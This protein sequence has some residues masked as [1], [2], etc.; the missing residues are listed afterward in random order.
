MT[1]PPASDARIV[2][3]DARLDAALRAVLDHPE[4][5]LA[6]LAVVT[7]RDGRVTYTGTFGR[8]FIDDT[9]PAGD[10][11]AGPHTRFR[12]ASISKLVTAAAVLQQVERGRVDLDA[13]AS[14]YLGFTLRNPRFPNVPVTAR[15]LLSHTSSLRDGE[16]Y[17]FPA[18]DRLADRLAANGEHD[19]RTH[20]AAPMATT[21]DVGP[22]RYFCYQNLNYGV[23]ATLLEAVSGERFDAYVRDHVLVPLGCAAS[24]DVR[25]FSP[26][27]LGDLGVLYR[28]SAGAGAGAGDRGGVWL[29]QV[30][31]LHGVRPPAPEGAAAYVPGTNATWQSPQGGLRISAWDLSKVM[32]MF[33]DGGSF[34]G[35]RILSP[36]SVALM[37]RPQWTYD[38]LHPN[39]DTYDDLMLCYGLGTQTM[40]DTLG[41]RLLADAA[42]P[43]SGHF[44]EAFGLLGGML[45]DFRRRD[46]FI[47]LISGAGADGDRAS[48]SYSSMYIWEEEIVTALFEFELL[49]R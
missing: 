46:G 45:M 43:M 9:D 33:L 41:D 39:G 31:D 22:G 25:D 49:A 4:R 28:R 44:G 30:D 13:D 10:L 40:T 14:T 1:P 18:T 37:F 36:T 15:M 11:P 17:T 16:G 32:R 5:P 48:G 20:W 12:V 23:L 26:R 2:G 8:R 47:Y 21:G 27:A 19:D 42:I 34:D 38:V 3:A 35:V 7:V 29:P 24:F 6:S